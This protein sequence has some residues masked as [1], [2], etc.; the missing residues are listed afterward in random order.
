MKA[1]EILLIFSTTTTILV[2]IL[3]GLSHFG[4]NLTGH[5]NI[6]ISMFTAAIIVGILQIIVP[7]IRKSKNEKRIKTFIEQHLLPKNWEIQNLELVNTQ[8]MIDGITDKPWKY[9]DVYNLT[10]QT[11]YL[12]LKKNYTINID[13]RTNNANHP[14]NK[15]LAHKLNRKEKEWA[16]EAGIDLSVLRKQWKRN[17][18]LNELGI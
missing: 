5:I 14:N 3:F 1:K 7:K 11:N 17:E 13:I 9:V 16:T 12:P 18:R 10:V 6:I 2:A 4:N 8:K 15:R